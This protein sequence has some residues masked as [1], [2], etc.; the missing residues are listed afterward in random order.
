MWE[1]EGG[2]GKG[3]WVKE[4]QSVLPTSHLYIYVLY[5]AHKTLSLLIH[6]GLLC[7]N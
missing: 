5:V 7:I 3:K 4:K 2:V 1:M 6:G